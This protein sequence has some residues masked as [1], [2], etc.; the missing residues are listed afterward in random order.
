[1]KKR[2]EKKD[3]IT[4][5]NTKILAGFAVIVVL[6][7]MQS[8][9][10]V[11]SLNDVNKSVET[12][13]EK[14]L[15]LLITNNAL[16]VDVHKRTSLVRGFLLYEDEA[17]RTQFNEELA[18]AIALE[19]TA[20][21]TS[22]APEMKK[23]IGRKISLGNLTDETFEAYD[24]G[25]KS[26]A[27]DIMNLQAKA[28]EQELEKGFSD[29]S[30]YREKRIQ[31]LGQEIIANGKTMRNSGIIVTII[32]AVFSA[33][34][35]YI[36]SRNITRPIKL[37]MK[38]M[39]EI[40]DGN[41]KVEPLTVATKDETGQLSESMNVM[42][43]VL[44]EMI[45]NLSVASETLT[46]NS[47]ELTQ[48]A[49][50]V[51]AGSEQVATTMQEL[52][53]GSETQANTASSL[54]IVMGNFTKKVQDTNKRGDQINKTSQQVLEM[55]NQ[56]AELMESSTQQMQKIDRIVQDTVEKMGTLD[57]QTKEISDLVSI[58]QTVAD[59]TNLLALNA[60]IE[61]A[62]AGEHGRGFAVVADEVRKLAEQV[63]VSIADIT[64]F[65][66][67]IQKESKNVRESLQ[68]GYTEVEEGTAQIKTTGKT[69]NKISKSVTSMVSEIQ[70]ISNNLESIAVNSEIMGSSIE[71][72]AAVSEES[73]AGVEETSAATQQISSSMEEVSGN[74]EHLAAL[75][76]NLSQMVNK[77]KL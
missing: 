45:H 53:T 7:M 38:Q 41:L 36:T 25:E 43:N 6:I 68:I 54:S 9:Y 18:G 4:S 11:I 61:A 28:L 69:F 48:S 27:E 46:A 33:I 13:M 62:R 5:L 51:K 56:G 77:F 8:M 21:E 52:A 24:N 12:V 58:I 32:V 17:Y 35:A 70:Q 50:E 60:A 29:L 47:E 75:A 64:G 22:D 19:N 63:A 20:L 3:R 49:F 14:E 55:T 42:Q 23:L 10:N 65:V 34:I 40:S 30:T 71:E 66:N 15:K 73:A 31:D 72:I 2:K 1:M 16:L 39:K 76:E 44:K 57:N 26:K 37:V 67:T 74:S 59:Q